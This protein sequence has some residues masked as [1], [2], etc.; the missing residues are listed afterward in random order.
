L[1]PFDATKCATVTSIFKAITTKYPK[2]ELVIA[3]Q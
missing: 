3:E 1:A 2:M